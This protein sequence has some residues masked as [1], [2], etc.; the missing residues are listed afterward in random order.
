MTGCRHSQPGRGSKI[1]LENLIKDLKNA[2]HGDRL[3]CTR[4]VANWFR[5]LLHGT[6]YRLL[7]A[8]RQRLHEHHSDLGQL[9]LDTLR[10]RLLKVAAI[11]TQSARRILVRQPLAHP[12]VSTHAALAEWLSPAPT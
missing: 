9:Q 7:H 1:P 6:A 10:L 5:P 8:L 2:L 3:S 12:W 11:V 4:F